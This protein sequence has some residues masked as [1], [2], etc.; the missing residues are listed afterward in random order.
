MGI[1]TQGTAGNAASWTPPTDVERALFEAKS[2]GDWDGYLRVLLGA[3]AFAY[4]RREKV[5]KLTTTWLPYQAADGREYFAVYTRGELLPRRPDVVACDISLPLAPEEWW[6]EELRGLLVNPGTP[7]EAFFPDARRK[8]RHWKALKKDVPDRGHD[9]DALVTRY[10]GPLH[11]PLAHGLACGTHLAVHNQ[12]VWNEVG[13]VYK[14]FRED[15]EILRDSWGTTD[16]VEWTGQLTYLLEGRNSP[17]E[18]EFALWVREQLV[19]QQPGA[20]TDPQVWQQVAAGTL[21]ERGAPRE[22]AE[23]VEGLIRQIVRYESRFRADG[24][25]PPDGYVTSALGYDYGRA[26]NYARWGVGARFAEP[27][28]AEQAIVRAGELCQET[29]TSWED[30][31][32]GYIL[33]RALRFDEESFGHMYSSALSPHRILTTDPGSPWRHLPFQATGPGGPGGLGDGMAG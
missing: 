15:T 2:R 23:V 27:A 28:E 31:S 26:V 8:R 12:V 33:G 18:P 20:H 30:F 11:G 17:A 19:R 25:L 13:D 4:A 32:A 16:R 9:D 7:T 22:T 14:D 24:L 10:D 21:Q 3:G 1:P 5:K 29:Y 6:G